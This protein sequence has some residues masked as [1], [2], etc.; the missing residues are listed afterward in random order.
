MVNSN[1]IKKL[2]SSKVKSTI[3]TLVKHNDALLSNYDKKGIH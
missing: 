3:K 2:L 1:L